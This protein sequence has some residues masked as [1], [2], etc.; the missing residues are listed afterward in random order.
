[1]ICIYVYIYTY[2]HAD[3]NSVEVGTQQKHHTSMV[4][5]TFSG[6]S[7][8]SEEARS[9]VQRTQR[10]ASGTAREIYGDAGPKS[11]EAPC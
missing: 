3:S 6:S 2:V 11:R 9:A 8:H 7:E 5:G 4:F 1:M 10:E